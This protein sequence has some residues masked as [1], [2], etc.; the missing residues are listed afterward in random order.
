VGSQR[1]GAGD[2]STPGFEC[3]RVCER[4]AGVQANPELLFAGIRDGLVRIETAALNLS[5]C[6][7]AE[8]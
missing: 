2:D 3:Y 5:G 6:H 4:A 1:L 7:E 8:Q